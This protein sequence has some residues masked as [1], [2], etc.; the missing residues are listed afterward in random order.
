MPIVQDGKIHI[1]QHSCVSLGWPLPP[2]SSAA[3]G[4]RV[5]GLADGESKGR[6][7]EEL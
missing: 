6:E 2:P 5:A 4:E 3:R 1:H 7:I